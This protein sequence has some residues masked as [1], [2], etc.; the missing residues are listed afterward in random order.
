MYSEGIAPWWLSMNSIFI[1]PEVIPLV[2]T[3]YII[4]DESN[5]HTSAKT[6]VFIE[7]LNTR[8]K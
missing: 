8:V 6:I 4:K 2:K 1:F 3:T 5:A 7:S